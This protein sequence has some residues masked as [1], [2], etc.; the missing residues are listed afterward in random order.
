MTYTTDLNKPDPST[1]MP[2]SGEGLALLEPVDRN[3]VQQPE[4]ASGDHTRL[5]IDE[6]LPA[7]QM[8]SSEDDQAGSQHV[9]VY[10]GVSMP[11]AFPVPSSEDAS[12]ELK[13]GG[14]TDQKISQIVEG[15]VKSS[16]FR[17]SVM[18]RAL[19][20]L[21]LP[22][23]KPHQLPQ[24]DPH[25][26]ETVADKLF[27]TPPPRPVKTPGAPRR[28]KPTDTP[29]A[30]M[31]REAPSSQPVSDLVVRVD[32]LETAMQGL[33]AVFQFIANRR[34]PQP[35]ST[36][37]QQPQPQPVIFI[38]QPNPQPTSLATSATSSSRF[39]SLPA[40]LRNSIYRYAITSPR[41][42]EID[43]A[44][45][46]IHQPP[47]LQTCKTIRNE[48]L[49]LFYMENKI[50]TNIHDWNPIVK[51][52]FQRLMADHKIRPPHLHH[53][54]TGGPNWKNLMDWLQAVHQGRIGAISD[55][56]GKQ[57]SIE[58]K[59][60]GVMFKIVRNA[61]GVSAWSQVEDLLVAHR[62]LLGM[63]DAKWLIDPEEPKNPAT[64]PATDPATNPVTG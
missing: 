2:S 39:L 56:V 3:T 35:S 15:L 19:D 25:A 20:M 48:A 18:N 6:T 29:H 62:E 22:R 50:S 34:R 26:R 11:G 42:I 46:S 51:Y 14:L 33:R 44:R 37:A 4:P 10:T 32:N 21:H 8:P 55:A 52:Q 41:T 49:R 28:T 16:P 45:W 57:R 23:T 12:Q 59:T 1:Q 61:T 43:K 53:Y 5:E 63:N 30:P 7:I 40:E 36:F 64:N 58:R 47:L 38:Q 24:L 13:N 31:R 54:F 17:A 60:V 27:T 9:D